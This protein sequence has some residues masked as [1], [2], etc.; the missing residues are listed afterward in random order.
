MTSRCA[1]SLLMLRHLI[2]HSSFP[3]AWIELAPAVSPAFSTLSTRPFNVKMRSLAVETML[4]DRRRVAQP[5]AAD[6]APTGRDSPL[7]TGAAMAHPVT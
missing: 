7:E 3:I 4:L 5:Q 1:A 6:A 2:T